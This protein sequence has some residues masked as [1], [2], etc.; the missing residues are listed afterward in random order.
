MKSEGSVLVVTAMLSEGI[1]V[2]TCGD[3]VV[4]VVVVVY[5]AVVVVVIEV[6]AIVVAGSSSIDS[7][8][9][10]A[11][12]FSPQL[13]RRPGLAQDLLPPSGQ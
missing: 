9:C 1:V 6:A 11:V 10:S 2:S 4:L 13:Y 7:S 5:V 3:M 8:A 12:L